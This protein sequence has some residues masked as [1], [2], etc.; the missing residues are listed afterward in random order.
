ME[1]GRIPDR[2]TRRAIRRLVRQRLVN[3]AARPGSDPTE[4]LQALVRDL[5][6]Q[7]I[8]LVP[9]LPNEQHYEVP[10]EFFRAVLGHR[11]KY[12]CAMWRSAGDRDLNA[13]EDEM[14]GLTADRAEIRDGQDILDLGCGWGSFSL[15]VAERYPRARVLAVSNSSPQRRFIEDQCRRRGLSNLTV[16]TADMNEFDPGRRFDRIVSVEMFEHMRNYEVLLRRIAGWLQEDGKLF[17][18]VFCHRELAYAFEDGGPGDW[19]ARHFF[20]GGLMPSYD[21]FLHFDADVRLDD[22]WTVSGTHYRRT[23][24]AWLA[25]LDACREEAIRILE[26]GQRRSEARRAF[27]RWRLFFLAVAELFGFRGGT[28]WRVAHYRFVRQ[29]SASRTESAA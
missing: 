3:E 23:A 13:A 21:L 25:N 1:S 18:H 7:P 16:V 17:V 14:L 15:W 20:S 22:R 6:Q 26:T 5:K 28:E 11:L 10:A 4:L 24:E 12:S 9:D 8:A 19:M 27:V 2:W 29:E